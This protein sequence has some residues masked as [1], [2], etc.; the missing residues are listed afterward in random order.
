VAWQ[1]AKGTIGNTHFVAIPANAKAKAAAQVFAN[2]LLSAEA[3]AKKNDLKVWGDP[4]VLAVD[5]LSADEQKLFAAVSAPGSVSL[6]GPALLEPHASWVSLLEGAWT[7]RY[8]T[9]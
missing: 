1:H 8:G 3:Q 4:T 9:G 5:K 2:F 7:K 6:P